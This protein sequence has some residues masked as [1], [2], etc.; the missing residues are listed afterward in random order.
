MK[1]NISTNS[2]YKEDD[3]YAMKEGYLAAFKCPPLD[4]SIV[5]EEE[6][7]KETRRQKRAKSIDYLN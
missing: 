3:A 7:P 4:K 6:E 2:N 5:L 1:D